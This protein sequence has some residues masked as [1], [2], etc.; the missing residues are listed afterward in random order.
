MGVQHQLLGSKSKSEGIWKNEWPP[1]ANSPKTS[2]RQINTFIV[3]EQQGCGHQ[4]DVLPLGKK[5]ALTHKVRVH[6]IGQLRGHW[7]SNRK[8]KSQTAALNEIHVLSSAVE[9]RR[10]QAH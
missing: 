10:R 9:C 1:P 7:L 3:N 2:R 8:Y 5:C 4:A 6:T